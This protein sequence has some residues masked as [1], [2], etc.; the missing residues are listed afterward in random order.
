ML[1][2][3]ESADQKPSE[4]QVTNIVSDLILHLAEQVDEWRSGKNFGEEYGIDYS[5]WVRCALMEAFEVCT[6][7]LDDSQGSFESTIN[8]ALEE[9]HDDLFGDSDY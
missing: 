4:D 9:R 8:S 1:E 6:R 2:A 3:T 5:E 7:E